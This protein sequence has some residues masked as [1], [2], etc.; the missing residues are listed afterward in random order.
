MWNHPGANKNARDLFTIHYPVT[1]A[2]L[3]A[4][5]SSSPLDFTLKLKFAHKNG[6]ENLQSYL[7]GES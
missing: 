3:Y 6:I 7:A 5:F 1:S 2:F 4:F